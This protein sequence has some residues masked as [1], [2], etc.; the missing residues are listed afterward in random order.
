MRRPPATARNSASRDW[1]ALASLARSVGQAVKGS[2]LANDVGGSDGP[3]A[4]ETLAGYLDALDRVHLLD[5]SE[6]WRPHMRSRSRLRTSSVRYFVDPS[7]GPA[8][9]SIGSAELIAD[10]QAVGFH[11][12]ALAV[13][14]LRIYA[15]R[16]RGTVDSWRD[17][18]GKEVDAVLA[19]PGG[20]GAFD[21]KLNPAAVDQAA[22]SLHRFA[23]NVDTTVHGQPKVLGVITS[24]GCAGRRP[25]GVQV[26][27]ISTLGP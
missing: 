12:E 7:L 21:V 19:T 25:D 3:I 16:L 4:K 8:A 17:S 6:S 22:A 26:V 20:W 13:R 15:Q 24:T 10:P 11:F 18:N 14:D 27:P 2:E 5:N 1:S 23:A 9:L